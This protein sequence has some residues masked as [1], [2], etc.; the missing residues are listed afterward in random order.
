MDG[1]TDTP[2]Y[3]DARTHLIQSPR[4]NKEKKRERL[5][6]KRKDYLE[7]IGEDILRE[8]PNHKEVLAI[9]LTLKIALESQ[10]SQTATS[11]SNAPTGRNS[12]L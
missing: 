7:K 1:L 11:T 6:N 8:N 12:V 10:S 3:R 9:L 5:G 4:K 2:S